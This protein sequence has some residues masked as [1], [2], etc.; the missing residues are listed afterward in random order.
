M[1]I[2]HIITSL[3]N[4]GAETM[5]YKLL[6]KMNKVHF[7]S[8]V[9]NLIERG[10]IC[11]RIEALDIPVDSVEMKRGIPTL[12]KMCQLFKII[13]EYEPAI[14]QGWMYHSNLLA[15]FYKIIARSEVPVLWNIRGSHTVLHKEKLLTAGTIWISAKLS[16][17]PERIINNSRRS[18]ISHEKK[19]GFSSDRLTIIPNG[20]DLNIFIPSQES[21]IKI[22]KEINLP[23]DTF[24][25]GMVGRYHPMKDHTNF[26]QAISILHKRNPNVHFILAGTGVDMENNEI[27][28]QCK[29]LN[30]QSNVI[31][32]LGERNDIPE[33]TA[34][35]DI[36][37]CSSY[38]EGFPNVIGEAMSCGV[39][40]VV[41]DVGDSALIVGNFGKIV[42]PRNPLALAEAWSELIKIGSEK[43]ISMGK[44]ARQRIVE[45][46][47]LDAIVQQ[48]EKLYEEVF[49][50]INF[51]NGSHI[52]P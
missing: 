37:S 47:S 39:P 45:N 17:L 44:L 27:A 34:A 24:L 12:T 10:P 1:K 28:G 46:F 2:I 13:K 33:L 26:L 48:Y 32:L 7:E 4:G 14:I 51:K 29:R 41:T 50:A 35:L 25:I 43:R 18:A 16:G 49:S 20:F 52:V 42:P 9:I 31:H 6:L 23:L 21:R 8:K 22:R 38:S 19:L 11:D 5:L 3:S 40:C 15:L 30:I 36:A